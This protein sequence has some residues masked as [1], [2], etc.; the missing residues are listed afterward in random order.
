MTSNDRSGILAAGHWI[1][2]HVKVIEAWPEQDSLVSIVSQSSGNGGCAYNVLKNLSKLDGAFPLEGVGLIGDD[3]DGRAILDDCAACGISTSRLHVS[4]AYST[5]YTDVM[6]VAE[7]GR[8]TFFHQRGANAFLREDHIRVNDSDARF[9]L[10]GYLALLDTLDEIGSDG[11]TGAS[12]VFEAASQAGFVTLADLV[13]SHTGDFPAM[14]GPS[15]PWIDW[16]FLNEFEAAKLVG[17]LMPQADDRD[18]LLALAADVLRLGVRRGVF[19]HSARAAFYVGR[20]GVA[21]SQGCVNVP[22]EL[23]QGT[24]GAGDAFASGCIL[25]LHEERPIRACLELGV[26][27]AACSLRDPSCSGAIPSADKCLSF[28][29]THG[30]SEL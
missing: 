4:D 11:R 7:G 27:A 9:F 30:F 13:S 24:A 22:R 8:R 25:A 12:R 17:G 26:A 28:A 18:G 14:I 1:V 6:T 10:L 16:L 23:I 3:A 21:E 20:D 19:L 15:L 2:D 29:K 5:S